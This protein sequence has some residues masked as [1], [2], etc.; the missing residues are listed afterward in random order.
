MLDRYACRPSADSAL[1]RDA[2]A[3]PPTARSRASRAEAGEGRLDERTVAS[4]APCPRSAVSLQ[5]SPARA[6][7]RHPKQL[8]GVFV[9]RAE[10]ELRTRRASMERRDI[11]MEIEP[12]Q[13]RRPAR[14]A[15]HN[16][17]LVD[18]R[19]DVPGVKR[20]TRRDAAGAGARAASFFL[21]GVGYDPFREKKRSDPIAGDPLRWGVVAG[22]A[23]DDLLVRH[24]GRRHLR[25]AGLAPAAERRTASAS[26]SSASSTARSCGG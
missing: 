4:R 8:I 19:R 2:S 25:A 17:T 6:A 14:A 20:R 5:A 12:Y 18:G 16:V 11:V 24:P 15:G 10:D 22:E 13:E 23:L 9:G 26:S 1:G 21:G 3:G 7:A